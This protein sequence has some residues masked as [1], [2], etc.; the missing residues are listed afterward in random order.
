[1]KA[2]LINT[3]LDFS[4]HKKVTADIDISR[5]D[6][7]EHY[8]SHGFLT[9]KSSPSHGEIGTDQGKRNVFTIYCSKCLQTLPNT[10]N[11]YPFNFEFMP[12]KCS[13]SYMDGTIIFNDGGLSPHRSLLAKKKG[14]ILLV[15]WVW[16][17]RAQNQ[18]Y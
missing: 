6:L 16:M 1:M 5:L 11:R 9:V 12:L 13:T 17:K 3:T 8:I 2:E 14:T 7:R 4:G 15:G 18:F 10:G